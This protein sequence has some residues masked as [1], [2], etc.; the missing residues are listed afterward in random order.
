MASIVKRNYADMYRDEEYNPQGF[1][2]LICLIT[3][4]I[5]MVSFVFLI[6]RCSGSERACGQNTE[7][8]LKHK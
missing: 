6:A 2:R 7:I 4:L 3:T 8:T 5:L 1:C